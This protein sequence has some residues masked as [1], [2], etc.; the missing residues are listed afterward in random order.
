[1]PWWVRVS[2]ADLVAGDFERAVAEARDAAVLLAPG[3]ANAKQ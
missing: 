3:G 1:M 2:W